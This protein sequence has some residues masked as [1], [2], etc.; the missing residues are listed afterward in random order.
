MATKRVREVVWEPP[1]PHYLMEKV[2]K[3]WTLV[4]LEWEREMSPD[5][6]R[7][8][9]LSRDVPYGLRVAADSLNL[10]ENPE[11]RETLTAM[12]NLIVKDDVPFSQIALELNQR[13]FRTREGLPWSQ[14]TVFEMLPR[15]VEVAPTIFSSEE[16]EAL[17]HRI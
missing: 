17:K 2:R 11:E 7:S 14:T 12:L 8:V 1:S 5:E 3:G 6:V 15:L 16:W 13:G 10:E 9:G 4:A